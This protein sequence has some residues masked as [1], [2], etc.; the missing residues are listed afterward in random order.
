MTLTAND[1]ATD[2]GL[3]SL[4]PA[5]GSEDH[6]R[7]MLLVEALLLIGAPVLL[8]AFTTVDFSLWPVH[9]FLYVTILLA[10]QYGIEGATLAV[11]G[12]T[13]ASWLVGWPE[14]PL[15][16]GREEFLMT[17]AAQPL[18]W[19]VAGLLVGIVT[20]SRTRALRN[21]RE[22]LTRARNA[23]RLIARQ[24]EVMAERTRKLERGLAGLYPSV[25]TEKHDPAPKAVSPKAVSRKRPAKTIHRGRPGVSP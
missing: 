3:D 22:H 4:L 9:P 15:G 13:L 17:V 16:V 5:A 2:E 6:S 1:R 14:R 11:V 21:Q 10:A 19:L 23:E 25:P 12:G 8:Q 7:P 18:S 20:S 24:Y